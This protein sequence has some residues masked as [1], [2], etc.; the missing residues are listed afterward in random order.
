M[1]RIDRECSARVLIPVEPLTPAAQE[2]PDVRSSSGGGGEEKQFVLRNP[3]WTAAQTK[4]AALLERAVEE[5]CARVR[6]TWKSGRNSRGQLLI[7]NAVREALQGAAMEIMLPDVITFHFRF[8]GGGNEVAPNGGHMRVV[9]L[10]VTEVDLVVRSR[11]ERAMPLR[12]SVSCENVTG[13]HCLGT[14]GDAS[15]MLW[16]GEGGG[17]LVGWD[18]NLVRMW[19]G[20]ADCCH[21]LCRLAGSVNGVEMAVPANGAVTHTFSLCFLVPGEYSILASALVPSH[22][23]EDA[24]ETPLPPTDTVPQTCCRGAP[25]KVYVEAR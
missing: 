20:G 23:L 21:P 5:L 8:R 10:E 24:G 4:A 9:A 22:Y 11:V 15:N 12:V 16:A 3:T 25:H 6:V 19:R 7:R 2:G 1:T 18:A 14:E 17:G 13:T